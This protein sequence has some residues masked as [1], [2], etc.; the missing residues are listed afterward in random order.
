MAT[1]ASYAQI[2]SSGSAQQ[3]QREARLRELDR[4]ELD[5]RFR[6]NPEV[7]LDQRVL[8]DYGAF[9]T[10]NYLSTDDTQNNNHIL[11]QYELVAYG[12][13]NLDNAQE[14]FFRGHTG[15]RDFNDGDSFDG[16]GDQPIDA[17][18]ER[19]YYRFDLRRFLSASGHKPTEGN[20]VFKA[21]RDLAY[22]SNG[23]TLGRTLDG[24][25]LDL[26]YGDTTLSLL[27]GL[28]PARTVD[29]DAS[30]PEF[31]TDTRRGFYGAML[32]TRVGAHRPFVYALV[33]RDY[34][35]NDP[36]VTGRVS[37]NFHYNS[38]YIGA[39]SSGSIGDR[40]RYGVEAVYE[41][42]RS[43]SNSFVIDANEIVNSGSVLK[44][45]KQTE[46]GIDAYALDARLEYFIP[47]GRHSRLSLEGIIAS[48]DKDRG[49]SSSTFNGNA[50]NSSDH[51]FNAFGLLNTGLAFG[52]DVSNLAVLRTGAA[53]VPVPSSSW[54][55]RMQVGTDL[56]VFAKLDRNAP[57]DEPTENNKRLLGFEG[58]LYCN[59][60]IASDVV[61]AA[62]YGL[63]LPNSSAFRDND[64]RQ[65]FYLGVTFAF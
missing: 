48:G 27:A 26:S 34:N 53:T 35:S 40:L 36:L 4:I 39:G 25:N 55:R 2:E 54:L 30:R 43:L 17:D 20:L 50:P 37:T 58:D 42:G 63:F 52:A 1:T 16:D 23:L 21:G 15:Y 47:D 11:R 6:A 3:L 8:V 19:A 13:L 44:Q 10:L 9:I 12:R 38:Y 60:Q 56:F 29:F 22:W 32:A 61:L 7:P 31:D 14:L 46:D 33:Q 62:R 51:A 57:I 64:A 65:F 49:N 18:F 59:W 24:A 5:T 28:T 45:V 41:G